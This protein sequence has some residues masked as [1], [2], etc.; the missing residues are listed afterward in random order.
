[1][2]VIDAEGKE[3]KE[4]PNTPEWYVDVN[5]EVLM[6]WQGHLFECLGV[7]PE[8]DPNVIIFRHKGPID[9]TEK[10]QTMEEAIIEADETLKNHKPGQNN[11][12][13]GRE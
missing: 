7:D 12:T 8:H 1:M 13:D 11:H 2:I 10:R 3:M 5:P 6:E 4:E 9:K